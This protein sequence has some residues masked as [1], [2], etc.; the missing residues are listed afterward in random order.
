MRWVKTFRIIWRINALLIFFT[1]L[2]AV[3]LLSIGL[4]DHFK[5]R[6]VSDVANINH[7]TVQ[8]EVLSITYG[9]RLAGTDYLLL[10]LQSDQDYQQSYF[11]KSAQAIRNYAFININGSQGIQWLYPHHHFLFLNAISLPSRNPHSDKQLPVNAVQAVLFNVKKYDSD[12]D[13]R[14]TLNDRGVIALAKPDGSRFKE[15]LSDVVKLV[16]HEVKGNVLFLVY[17][18]QHNT[19]AAWF[20]LEDFTLIK[21]TVLTL[22]SALAQPQ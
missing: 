18:T 4:L 9:E 5:L 15:V 2:L 13:Q 17:E 20:S 21:Q 22:P 14:L 1:A 19:Q 8:Q 6:Q 3:V 10:A 7:K 11:S 12:K 16:T